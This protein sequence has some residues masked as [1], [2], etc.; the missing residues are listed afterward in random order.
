MT[1]QAENYDEGLGPSDVY[2]RRDCDGSGAIHVGHI[3][4]GHPLKQLEGIGT[5][6]GKQ[7]GRHLA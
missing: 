4:G 6:N 3:Q 1:S 2:Q 7:T 5:K